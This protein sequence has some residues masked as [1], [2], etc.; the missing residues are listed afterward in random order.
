MKYITGT[1]QNKGNKLLAINTMPDHIH[2]FFGMNPQN[3]IS[4]LVRDIKVSSTDFVNGKKWLKGKFH[5]QKGFGAFSYSHSQIDKVINYIQ[6]QEKHHKRV[7]F[8][9]EY[10][11]MLKAFDIKYDDSYL[12]K[13]F[14][15]LKYQPGPSCW[16]IELLWS[17]AISLYV[18]ILQVFNS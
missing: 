5:Q 8:K 18:F 13:W 7:T 14:D 16:Y 15:E 9:D 11:Q 1:I 17:S 12:F 6:N 2:L 10:I 4:D 3:A